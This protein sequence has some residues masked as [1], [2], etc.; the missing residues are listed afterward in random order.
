LLEHSDER[1]APAEAV[2]MN[3]IL[4][5]LDYDRVSREQ[6]PLLG[7]DFVFATFRYASV[8]EFRVVHLEL[9]FEETPLAVVRDIYLHHAENPHSSLQ[10]TLALA[11]N[12]FRDAL[13][14]A[15]H[16]ASAYQRAIP[17]VAVFNTT[18]RH[19]IGDF[20]VAWAWEGKGEPEVVA[21][22]RN[23]A[24]VGIQGH[25]AGEHTLALATELDETLS[26]LKTT[27]SYE[28]DANGLTAKIRQRE[29]NVPR[30]P[31]GGRL[32]LGV[33]PKEQSTFFLTSSGSVNRDP[34]NPSLRYFRAGTET[35]R[36]EITLFT[37]GEGIL[38]TKESLIVE[39]V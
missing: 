24:F 28:E 14:L 20:G 10:L 25:D 15:A 23:N 34:S 37:L 5:R 7:E 27:L 29:G 30:V 26:G 8:A 13:T 12:G 18:V 19:G 11:W 1:N 9:H 2:A 6:R 31:S 33:P 16:F 32:D 3:E 4:A 21:F 39:V 22:V 38:P 17:E 36:Q 35:G